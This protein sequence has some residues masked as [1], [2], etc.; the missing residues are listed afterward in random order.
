MKIYVS[1]AKYLPYVNADII[2][3]LDVVHTRE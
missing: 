2:S 1:Y 3:F